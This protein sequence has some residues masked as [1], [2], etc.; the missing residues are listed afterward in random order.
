LELFFLD[1]PHTHIN[2]NKRMFVYPLTKLKL[3]FGHQAIIELMVFGYVD[4]GVF[5][6]LIAI[7]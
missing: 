4:L 7:C 5:S 6:I 3:G 1:A 2:H